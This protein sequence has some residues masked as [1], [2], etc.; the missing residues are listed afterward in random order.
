MAPMFGDRFSSI[1]LRRLAVAL[2]AAAVVT[3]TG[4]LAVA[5][6]SQ[7]GPATTAKKKCKKHGKKGAIAKKRKKCKGKGN[8]SNP[9]GGG[10][11][12][13]GGSSGPAAL[14]IT[15][16]SKDFG[17]VAVGGASAAQTFVVSNSGGLSGTLTWTTSGA[18]AADFKVSVDVCSG[19]RLATGATCS[20]N[21]RFEPPGPPAPGLGPRTGTLT[22]E[23]PGTPVAAALS[24]TGIP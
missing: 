22:V 20:L 19:R 5:H 2:L 8:G 9:G 12:P 16:A 17:N 10:K 11:T 4:L 23:A 13:G 15:P 3:S 24:G 6:A 7:T 18:D 1:R 14:S 21:V